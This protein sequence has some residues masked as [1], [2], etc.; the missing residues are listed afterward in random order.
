MIDFLF[1]WLINHEDVMTYPRGKT[2][3]IF[4]PCHCGGH[5]RICVNTLNLDREARNLRVKCGPD[6]QFGKLGS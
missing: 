1:S 6:F 3:A 2:L 4:G 5:F